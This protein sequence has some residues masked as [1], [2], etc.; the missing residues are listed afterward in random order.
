MHPGHA[1]KTV[2]V[3][4][5]F[6]SY[7]YTPGRARSVDG[8]TPE[9]TEL[10]ERLAV[11]TDGKPNPERGMRVLKDRALGLLSLDAI[12]DSIKTISDNRSASMPGLEKSGHMSEAVMRDAAHADGFDLLFYQKNLN[13]IQYYAKP[14]RVLSDT[15]DQPIRGFDVLEDLLGFAKAHDIDVVLTIQPAHVSRLELLDRMGYWD[16]Y[17]RWKRELVTLTAQARTG[18]QVTLWDFGGYQRQVQETVPAKGKGGDMEWFW[19]PVHYNSKF[20][21]MLIANIFHTGQRDELGVILTP[22]NVDAQIARVRRDREMFR[23][24]QPEETARLA[25]L[26]SNALP[27]PAFVK[28]VALAR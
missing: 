27:A 26:V 3:G 24:A 17:E 2:V 23:A 18:Q 21:D 1:P 15:P 7:L 9:T 13:V 6:E 28:N 8:K 19:D 4:L 16:D 22:E 14:H 11:D 25:R 12:V 5:D 10:D 20:G